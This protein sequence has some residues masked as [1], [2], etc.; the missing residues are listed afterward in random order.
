[1]KAPN[2]PSTMDRRTFLGGVGLL[3][4]GLAAT[5]LF[6]CASAGDGKASAEESS[7][8]AQ[9]TDGGDAWLGAEPEISDEEC[10]ETLEVEIL[11]VGGGTG[12]WFAA[13]AAAEEGADVL[14]IDKLQT[15]V[16]IRGSVG[17]VESKLHA[18][19]GV[20]ID[21]ADILNDMIDLGNNEG[22]ARLIKRWIDESGE[23]ADWYI[24][25]LTRAGARVGLEYNMPPEETRYACW[26]T[27]IYSYDEETSVITEAFDQAVSD[28]GGKTRYQT[29]MVKLI[30]EEDG[31]VGAYATNEDG[32]Y[33]R[34][35]ASKGVVLATGGY[36][37]NK[38]MYLALQKD[39]AKSIVTTSCWLSSTG[40]GIKAALWAGA[41][42]DSV[43]SSMVFDRGVVPLEAEMKGPWDS[44]GGLLTFGSQ[45]WLQ[46][47]ANGR[48]FMN[49]SSPYD[50]VVHAAKNL[51]E[52]CWYS[53][54]DSNW[55]SDIERFH[56][57]NCSTL[58][59]REGGFNGHWFTLNKMSGTEGLAGVDMAEALLRTAVEG[60]FVCEADTLEEICEKAGMP[61]ENLDATVERYNELYDAQNDEDFGKEA[62]RL[63]AVRTPPFYLARMGGVVLCTLDG[64]K[65]DADTMAALDT[66]GN[67][68]EGLYMAGVDLGGYFG[69][70]YDNLAGGSNAG[71][72]AT[73][74]RSLGKALANA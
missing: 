61:Y 12:G 17:A 44:G 8:A 27:L 51:P 39:L 63:S 72:M 65:V 16:G 67:P 71:R 56:T 23:T 34:I 14:L 49:E 21:K 31:V 32:E 9:S 60:G 20:T 4:T 1:M 41:A 35:N 29:T 64:I 47:D 10:V 37:G 53:L 52:G 55:K 38:D 26:P 11:V 22:D 54:F 24:D 28:A 48:R 43:K 58:V 66:D 57:I 33:I 6:G 50:F 13:A 45:P 18:E 59:E 42:F 2:E 46:V 7:P 19:H 68:I 25:L 40:D 62:F 5:G 36:G 30:K 74:G 15:P 69:L 3:G 73:L 70:S